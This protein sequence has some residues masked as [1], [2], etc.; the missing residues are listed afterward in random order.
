MTDIRVVIDEIQVQLDALA[1]EHGALSTLL[2]TTSTGEALQIDGKATGRFCD[3]A[4][5]PERTPSA[6]L[7]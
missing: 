7:H 1:A 6:K 2:I 4:E 3:E 5:K